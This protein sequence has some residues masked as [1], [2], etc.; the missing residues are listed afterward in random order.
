[1][2]DGEILQSSDSRK[3]KKK[4]VVCLKIS[5]QERKGAKTTRKKTH[6]TCL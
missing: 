3:V 2:A 1:M 6:K 5:E 4:N